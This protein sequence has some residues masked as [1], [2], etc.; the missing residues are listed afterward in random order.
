MPICSTGFRLPNRGIYGY[1]TPS[2]ATRARTPSTSGAVRRSNCFPVPD[3]I[4]D[5]QAL[6]LS[7][8]VPTG[9][10]GADFCD[11]SAGDTVAVWGAGGVGLMAAKSALLLGADRVIVIDRFPERLEMARTVCHAETG[12]HRLQR[13]R[14]TT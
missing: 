7:D 14:G 6:F 10:M 12:L 4:S 2:G 11:I 3:G 5:E 13:A 9:Y 8:A 1:T